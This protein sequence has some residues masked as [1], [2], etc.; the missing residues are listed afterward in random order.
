MNALKESV[1]R[2]VAFSAVG[3]CMD[4]LLPEGRLKRAMQVF[5]GLLAV[6]TIIDS[7]VSLI[8]RAAQ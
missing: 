1:I 2:I 3:G 6:K 8:G 7:V 5:L 4:L